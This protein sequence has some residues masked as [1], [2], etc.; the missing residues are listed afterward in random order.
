VYERAPPDDRARSVLQVRRP[1]R[2]QRGSGIALRGGIGALWAASPANRMAPIVRLPALLSKPSSSSEGA[3][4][5]ARDR[6][7]GAA[8][9]RG[10][11]T[12]AAP[13]LASLANKFLARLCAAADWPNGGLAIAYFSDIFRGLFPSNPRGREVAGL[14]WTERCACRHPGFSTGRER[15]AFFPVD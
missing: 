6:D 3:P 8:R 10:L 15:G 5:G 14:I 13:E 1:L 9:L 12:P 11:S 4:F 7:N 2:L